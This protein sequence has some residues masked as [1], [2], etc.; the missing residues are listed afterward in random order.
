MELEFDMLGNSDCSKPWDIVLEE[1]I[2]ELICK[3]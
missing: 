3:E 2:P 1:V